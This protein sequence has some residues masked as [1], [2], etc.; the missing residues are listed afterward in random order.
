[1]KT[2]ENI[3]NHPIMKQVLADS[4]GGCLYDVADQNKYDGPEK[5]ELLSLWDDLDGSE[6]SVLG[7]IINGAINFLKGD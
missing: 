2:L 4:C 3:T 6:K 5:D 7:G 1:M